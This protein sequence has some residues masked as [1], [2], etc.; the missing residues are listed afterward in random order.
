[1]R[2]LALAAIKR[3]NLQKNLDIPIEAW[4][5]IAL[6]VH[7]ENSD[8]IEALWQEDFM[9]LDHCVGLFSLPSSFI[10]NYSHPVPVQNQFGKH[11]TLIPFLKQMPPFVMGMGRSRD[12]GCVSHKF[13]YSIMLDTNA[14]SHIEAWSRG[15]HSGQFL[16]S[17]SASVEYIV[18]NQFNF[19]WIPYVVENLDALDKPEVLAKIASMEQVREMV[20]SGAKIS[21]LN[22]PRLPKVID[23][24]EAIRRAKSLLAEY[25]SP[26][27]ADYFNSQKRQQCIAHVYILQAAI[28]ML[29]LSSKLS[30]P[31]IF[32][33]TL[34]RLHDDFPLWG[35]SEFAVLYCFI[36]NKNKFRFYGPV[37]RE[38]SPG[39]VLD[40]IRAMAWDV[41]HFR[42]L[43]RVS[44]ASIPTRNAPMLT[45]LLSFDPRF[46][47]LV[48]SIRASAIVMNKRRHAYEAVYPLMER[49]IESDEQF[50]EIQN[51]F[52]PE[53]QRDRASR[54]PI[55]G[56]RFVA[57]AVERL[58]RELVD[59]LEAQNPPR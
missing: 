46:Q 28:T 18:S 56:D 44:S 1:M 50:N 32:I 2:S 49:T 57:D 48:D 39:K 43:Y 37:N 23:D 33:E 31:Q 5:E 59:V 36:Y 15:V 21:L 19:D 12:S 51:F 6:A 45:Y 17:V 20:R 24:D 34:K 9:D 13:D 55:D 25:R 30:V 35:T 52:G 58:K 10:V 53:A 38:A 14:V 26:E 47:E 7:R 11:G 8:L 40:K 54:N 4:R 29:G 27:M 3:M 22:Q 16:E 41:S 42:N